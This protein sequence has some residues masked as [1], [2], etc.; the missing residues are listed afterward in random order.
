MVE[1][2]VS[3]FFLNRSLGPIPFSFFLFMF[4]TGCS[5]DAL[6]EE[7]MTGC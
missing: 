3:F 5:I 6:K 4:E 7:E 2:Y 1:V